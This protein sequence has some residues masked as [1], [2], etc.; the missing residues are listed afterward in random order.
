M[1]KINAKKSMNSAQTEDTWNRAIVRSNSIWAFFF[2]LRLFLVGVKMAAE[3]LVKE[4]IAIIQVRDDS[5]LDWAG[6]WKQN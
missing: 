5:G 4:A 2:Y 6:E 1:V 3:I